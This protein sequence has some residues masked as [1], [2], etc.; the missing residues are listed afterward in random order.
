[1]HIARLVWSLTSTVV[2][3]K[4]SFLHGN[5]DDEIYMDVTMGLSVSS[6][7]KLILR[8]TIYSL[9]QSARKFYKS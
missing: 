5:L 9:V 4:T 1:M 2:D 8:K 7:K 3:S 6:N